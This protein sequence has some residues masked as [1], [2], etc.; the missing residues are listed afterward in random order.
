MGFLGV[1]FE[2]GFGGW[3]G[4][5]IGF[6]VWGLF[7]CV[8]VWFWDVGFVGDDGEF[9]LLLLLYGVTFIFFFLIRDIY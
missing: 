1:G 5:F 8:F 6:E 9:G 2:L 4:S 3:L 7:C